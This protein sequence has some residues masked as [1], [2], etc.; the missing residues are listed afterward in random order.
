MGG[1]DTSK[2]LGGIV[3]VYIGNML[4]LYNKIGLKN[5]EILMPEDIGKKIRVRFFCGIK[6]NH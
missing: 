3:V 5:C 1:K 6:I 4:F 2:F